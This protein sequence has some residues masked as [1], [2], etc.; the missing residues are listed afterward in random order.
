MRRESGKST[1]LTRIAPGILVAATG[2]GAGDLLSAS[3]A[4]ANLGLVILWAALLGAVLKYALT[5]GLARWQLATE[6]TLLEGW[7]RHLGPLVTVPFFLY[8]VFWAFVTA[9]ALVTA[10][11]V[12]GVGLYQLAVDGGVA[13]Q[14]D[15]ERLKVV[16]GV[17]Q[18]LL[19]V[20]LV[21]VGG[22]R[23]FERFMSVC[24]AVMFAAVIVT[25]VLARPDPVELL[26]GFVPTW[27]AWEAIR[28]PAGL[29]WTLGVIGGVG[30]TVTLLS[31]G[32]WIREEN[33]SG[34]AGL[35]ACRI[36]LAI[37]YV[38]TALFGVAMIVIASNL[39][40]ERGSRMALEL[41]Q[42]LRERFGGFGEIA[43]VLFLVGFWG[44]VFSSLLGVWQSVPYLFADFLRTTGLARG[45]AEK[46][47]ASTAAYRAFLVGMALSSLTLL[48]FRV[49]QIQLAYAVLGAV[50]MPGLALTLL[51][52]N[53]RRRLVGG[54]FVNAWVANG[55]LVVTLLFF[56]VVGVRKIMSELG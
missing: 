28:D 46:P 22:F 49:A 19:G 50:F 5:E 51:L 40:L 30:G 13:P 56:A 4:G 42:Q 38:M 52:L 1:L 36:D 21:L 9:G 26:Y 53:N 12:A 20:V 37:G 8:F 16:F 55:A 48:G 44:A 25:A 43:R 10:S 2:V 54:A 15:E 23:F 7:H 6:T 3:L 24:I 47:L 27:N 29:G 32:Y 35:K 41:A 18:S 14:A 39:E 17:L 31:Y 34:A 33:R 45:D 11:G